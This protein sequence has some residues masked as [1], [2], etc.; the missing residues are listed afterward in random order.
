MEIM[1]KCPKCNATKTLKKAEH[2]TEAVFLQEL[3]QQILCGWRGCDGYAVR[4][5]VEIP[6]VD[7][8][9]REFGKLVLSQDAFAIL[10]ITGVDVI[11]RYNYKIDEVTAWLE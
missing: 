11:M 5:P 9:R 6:I 7:L 4:P 8:R 1:Y 3:P 10:R 2:Q